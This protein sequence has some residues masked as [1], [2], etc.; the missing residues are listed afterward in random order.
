MKT[1]I[2]DRYT[3]NLDPTDIDAIAEAAVRLHVIHGFKG[4]EMKAIDY[5]RYHTR[6]TPNRAFWFA[7][8][9]CIADNASAETL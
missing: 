7:V 4:G 2:T 5:A 8:A 1:Q 3:L 9:Q 6:G